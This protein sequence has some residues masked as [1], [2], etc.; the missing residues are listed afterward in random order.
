MERWVLVPILT[1]QESKPAFLEKLAGVQRLILLYVIDQQRTDAPAGLM[2]T[3]IK[4]A[5]AVMTEIRKKLKNKAEVK[6]IVE[7]GSWAE[8]AANIAALEKVDEVIGVKSKISEELEPGLRK[9]GL[10][11]TLHWIQ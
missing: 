5:E 6:E 7:W 8:K 3:R 2:G 10:K 11:V 4:A 9:R 1:E